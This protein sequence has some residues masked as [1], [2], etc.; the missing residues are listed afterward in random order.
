[1]QAIIK[2]ELS[3]HVYRSKTNYDPPTTN[4]KL[5]SMYV[6]VGYFLLNQVIKGCRCMKLMA[7]ETEN[8]LRLISSIHT[9]PTT[10]MEDPI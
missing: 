5:W 9:G 7:Q 10:S 2:H 4:S 1:M 6:Q 8:L 3:H